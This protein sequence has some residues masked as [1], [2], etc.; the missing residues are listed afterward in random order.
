MS[1]PARGTGWEDGLAAYGQR[2]RR[3]EVTA[4]QAIGAAL[5][6][7]AALDG[8]HRAFVHVD[9][10]RAQYAAQGIDTLL[11]GGVDLGPLM[12]APVA[13]KDLFAVDGMPT[14]AGSRLDLS[15]AVGPEGSLI[16]R[17][18]R[19]GA[20]ILGKAR[21]VEFAAGAQNTSHPTPWNPADP[22][23]HR[24]P[25]GSSN[26]SAVAVAAGYC[27]IAIGS[28]TGGSVRAPAALCGVV[29]SKA[30]AQSFSME[31][32]FPLCP[33][34]D[35]VGFFALKVEDAALA[36]SS[37]TGEDP[38]R[39]LNDGL[40]GTR[41]GVLPDRILS[42]LDTTVAEAYE[43][44][45]RRLEE[46]GV[47]LVS[48]DWPDPAELGQ[49]GEIYAA[50]VPSDLIATLDKK[51]I[52]ENRDRID[53]VALDRL[54]R[55]NG[56]EAHTYAAL[57]RARRA[58]T[59]QAVERMAGLDAVIQPTSP[60]SAPLVDHVS[61]VAAASAFTK[62]ALGLTRLAN[63]YGFTA[64]SIPLRPGE[65]GLPVGLDITGPSGSDLATLDLAR[66]VQLSLS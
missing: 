37:L 30:S 19:A 51:R 18:K 41:F 11:A 58:L 24:S 29:G 9:A 32:A 13:V 62:R 26:G 38:V 15:H 3:G 6:R 21:M 8:K 1:A 23:S 52:E 4:A 65:Q 40:A 63:V 20:V 33:A 17:L 43:A 53:P 35:S 64:C 46:A 2:L 59:R 39:A 47:S 16:R 54:D 42:D 57:S 12:G 36:H 49:I 5:D 55:A 48:L 22:D 25:G 28:D 66:R 45:L 10:E 34:M 31:G 7:I 56:I 27:P 14:R 50:L 61:E 44:S 60:V